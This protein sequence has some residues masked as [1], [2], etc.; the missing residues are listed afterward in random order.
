[1]IGRIL[2][3]KYIF[4]YSFVYYLRLLEIMLLNLT[5]DFK[6]EEIL[7][8]YWKITVCIKMHVANDF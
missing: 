5:V 3:G 1:M 4:M 6:Q 8:L 7:V 2:F